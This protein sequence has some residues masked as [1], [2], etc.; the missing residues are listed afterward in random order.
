M[1]KRTSRGL[2]VSRLPRPTYEEAMEERMREDKDNQEL[3]GGSEMFMLESSVVVEGDGSV[4]RSGAMGTW[5][6]PGAAGY[7][8]FGVARLREAVATSDFL[9]WVSH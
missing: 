1:V 4:L 2:C 8:P 6:R 5:S 7:V 3:Q 9:A